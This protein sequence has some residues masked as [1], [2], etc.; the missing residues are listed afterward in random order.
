MKNPVIQAIRYVKS[1]P[2]E[3]FEGKRMEWL[4]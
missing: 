1:T 3:G 4:I 2:E